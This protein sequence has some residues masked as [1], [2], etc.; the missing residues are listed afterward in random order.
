MTFSEEGVIKNTGFGN[1]KKLNNEK[2]SKEDKITLGRLASIRY[3]D[4]LQKTL[5]PEDFG[6]KKKMKDLQIENKSLKTILSHIEEEYTILKR[7][8]RTKNPDM[9]H[10]YLQQ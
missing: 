9:W 5:Y 3:W 8:I 7:F 2:A 4:I 10:E 1:K 6:L